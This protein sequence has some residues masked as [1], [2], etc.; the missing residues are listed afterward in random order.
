MKN[1]PIKLYNTLEFARSLDAEDPLARFRNLY[2]IP[3]KTQREV[4]YL[5]GNSLGLLPRD[6]FTHLEGE[7]FD[8]AHYG[9]DGHFRAKN[10]WVSYHERLAVPLANITGANKN[11][12]VAMNS[13]TVNLHLLLVSF[14]RP[15]KQRHKIICEYRPFPSD[16][17]ALDSQ[18]RFHGFDPTESLVE[19]K[20]REGESCLRTEDILATIQEHKDSLALVMMGGVNY[21]TGQAFDMQAITKKAHA[22][23][24]MAG[25]DLAHA[26]GNIPLA[27][28]AWNVDFAC[29]CSYKYLNS[30]PGG[31]G[32][33][34]IHE[35]HLNDPS[36][37]R[38]NGWWGGDAKKKFLMADEFSPAP[39]AEAWQ[40][41]NA[42][43]LAMSAH[44]TALT[45]FEEAGMMQLRKKS[46]LLTS[47]LEFLIQDIDN[48]YF[49]GEEVL[50]IITPS[51][52]TQRGCQLSLVAHGMGRELHE[53][54][55]ECGVVADWREPDVIRMAP[56][57]MYN[58]FE[59][60]WL[61]WSSLDYILKKKFK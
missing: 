21:I 19:L 1:D 11:E 37:P 14:Y 58:S 22:C 24:A 54:L 43:V 12:V 53:A 39:T 20:P 40:L 3:R 33:V 28:H 25:F 59:D 2:Y 10:P 9:V 49:K 5:T 38:F 23:G 16:R 34:F 41:S 44:H 13:L 45:L 47:L 27:L 32:G 50:E 48:T 26:I 56:V 57:P 51:D 42:P 55:E 15:T 60:V 35:K 6:T 18:I 4:V 7:L 31:V 30:G 61:V 29:W 46:L 17:Y 36:I 52:P 8:W